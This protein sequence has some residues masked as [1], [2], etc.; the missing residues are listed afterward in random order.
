MNSRYVSLT[1]LKADAHRQG[2]SGSGSAEGSL[3][4]CRQPS[5]PLCSSGAGKTVREL[6]EVLFTSAQIQFLRGFKAL[7]VQKR[8]TL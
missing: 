2:G 7:F 3:P 1:V 5:A 6:T 8:A 4:G